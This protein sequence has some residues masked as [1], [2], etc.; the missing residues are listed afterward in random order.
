MPNSKYVSPYL[1]RP[2]RSYAEAL[3]ELERRTPRAPSPGEPV[4]ERTSN[5]AGSN[6]ERV[7]THGP[8]SEHR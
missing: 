5:A 2:L 1:L 3:R 8:G 7:R 4:R 6:D